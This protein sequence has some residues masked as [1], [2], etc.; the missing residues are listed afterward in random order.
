[1]Q[2]AQS[3]QQILNQASQQLMERQ[4]QDA[5]QQEAHATI[6]HQAL[7]PS[8]RAPPEAMLW[9]SNPAFHRSPKGPPARQLQP[10][11]SV[12]VPKQTQDTTQPKFVMPLQYQGKGGKGGPGPTGVHM[13]V[14]MPIG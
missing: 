5:G 2:C 9:K 12:P 8:T 6:Q 4:R 1:M 14:G 3:L 7:A 10:P 11:M 13:P